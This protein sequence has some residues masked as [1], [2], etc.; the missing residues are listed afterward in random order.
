MKAIKQKLSALPFF[1]QIKDVQDIEEGASH[2]CFKVIT[3]KGN[4][5]AKYFESDR[6]TRQNEHQITLLAAQVG[7]TPPVLHCSTHWLITDFIE[8]Q[9]LNA[10]TLDK[11]LMIIVGLINQ[12]HQ[13][14]ARLAP[15]NLH[16]ILDYLLSDK[17]LVFAHVNAIRCVIKQ[18]PDI[19]IVQSLVV[20]HG[21]VNFSN[22]L[23]A[24]KPFLIDFEYA[25][26]AEPEYDLAM[27]IA[28]NLL[29]SA[30]QKILLS[31][32]EKISSVNI[33]YENLNSYLSYCY[34]INGLWCLLKAASVSSDELVQRSI[35]QFAAFDNLTGYNMQVL[36]EMR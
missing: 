13:L 27:I 1:D 6:A 22:I 15:L 35:K 17:T 29:N 3:A 34:L 25:C 23:F 4:Y 16:A 12:C 32:Y 21:D 28:I 31:Q 7:I 19:N 26:L 2:S 10:Q 18:L 14:K 30:Q 8:T 33:C 20:C 36:T 11:K 5:F 24:K 9:C